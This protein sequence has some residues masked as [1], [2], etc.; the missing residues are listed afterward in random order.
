MINSDR[1]GN[2]M[3]KQLSLALLVSRNRPFITHFYHSSVRLGGEL[4]G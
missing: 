3:C 2:Q 1:P 4:P